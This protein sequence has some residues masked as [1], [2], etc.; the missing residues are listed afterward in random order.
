MSKPRD[1]EDLLREVAKGNIKVR[2]KVWEDLTDDQKARYTAARRKIDPGW[3][4]PD[5]VKIGRKKGGPKPPPL[6]PEDRRRQ[7]PICGAKRHGRSDSGE[8][9]CCMPA[10]AGTDHKGRGACWLHGGRTHGHLVKDVREQ[11]MKNMVIYGSPIDIDSDTAIIQELRRTAGHVEWL[12]QQ[13]IAFDDPEQLKVVT[14]FGVG[15]NYW[16]T[17]YQEE[18]QHLVNVAKVAKSMNIT[19]RQVKI[20]EDQ[21]KMIAVAFMKFIEHQL[22]ELTPI[23][24]AN[25]RIAAREVLL[26][27]DVES[28]EITNGEI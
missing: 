27:I 18:R 15:K 13:I 24:K 1:F 7:G 23:Q 17:L 16:L 11:A 28:R 14:A 21:A 3:R 9:I 10:G 6:S 8:G 4:N 20:Q 2:P 22:L 5:E 26:A 25:A 12:H 19:E